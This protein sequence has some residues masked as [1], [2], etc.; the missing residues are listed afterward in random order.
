MKRPNTEQCGTHNTHSHI[1]PAYLCVD[2]SQ[3]ATAGAIMETDVGVLS[4]VQLVPGTS[5]SF[6]KDSLL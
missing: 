2:Q 1:L 4:S 5:V 6:I 3:V